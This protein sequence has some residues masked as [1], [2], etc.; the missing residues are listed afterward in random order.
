MAD[1]AGQ[2]D[3][4]G[5]NIDKTARNYQNE[6]SIFY[7]EVEVISTSSRE[8][9]WYQRTSGYLT[10]TS[11][12]SIKI[13]EGAKPFVLETSWTRNTSYTKKYSVDSPLITLEDESDSEVKVFMDNME[14][15]VAAIINDRDKDIY[16]VATENDTPVNIN[17]N[18]TTAAWDAGSGQDP[19]E[20][21][22]EAIQKIR[23]NTNRKVENPKLYVSAKGEKDLKVWVTS[24][25][26]TYFTELAS[27]TVVDGVLTRFAGC[28]VVVS[29]NVTADKA[30]VGELK[31]S[32]EYRE[33]QPMK[34]AIIEEP[35]IGRKI[36]AMTNGIAI[37]VRPKFNCLITNTEA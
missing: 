22:S 15:I 19:M 8:I 23:E 10:A 29:E 26:G 13:A 9:R 35:L 36:R 3:I 2:A 11:P 21:V 31:K 32:T 28:E 37:L 16:N 30:L 24:K 4:R 14:E 18:A 12:A 7:R 17:T 5:I 27:K 20:D 6:E 34:T 33:F 1:T 25:A